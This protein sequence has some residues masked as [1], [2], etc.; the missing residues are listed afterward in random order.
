MRLTCAIRARDDIIY[1]NNWTGADSE[2]QYCNRHATGCY[3]EGSRRSG[4]LAGDEYEELI[5]Q[6]MDIVCQ[7]EDLQSF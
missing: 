6:E 2:Q 7:A 5:L 4:L 3:Q 1:L